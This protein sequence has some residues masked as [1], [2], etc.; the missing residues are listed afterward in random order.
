MSFYIL[1]FCILLLLSFLKYNK[2][3]YWGTIFSL[4]MIAGLRSEEIGVDTHTY[5]NIFGWISDGIIYPIEP[6]WYLLNRLIAWGGSFNLLLLITSLLTLI[7]IGVVSLRCSSTPQ[8]SL[9][10]YYGLYAYI[11]SFNG[12]R[13][14]VA[15]SFVLLAYSYITQK[16]KFWGYL[17]VASMFHYSAIFSFTAVLV[18]KI[19]LTK[20]RIISGIIFS[21]FIGVFLNNSIFLVIVGPYAGYLE[22]SEGYRDNFL[23]AAIM[24]ILMNC[25]YMCVFFTLRR[26]YKQNLW[27][28]M[29]F[30]GIIILNITMR[31]ELGARIILYF[32]L[33]QIIF[34]PMFF[35]YNIVKNKKSLF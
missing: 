4:V 3:I 34:Y 21:L 6:A 27:T 25:L 32:T 20:Q 9:F 7:P 18:D 28:K 16:K 10:F 13:Q 19:S 35:R 2:Y 1:L 31:L 23:L 8:M 30:V 14:F 29:F 24:A 22:S 15:I 5:K 26:E 17:I 12:M 33:C 11:N